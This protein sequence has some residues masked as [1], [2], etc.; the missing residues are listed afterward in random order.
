MAL[1]T[2]TGCEYP[3]PPPGSRTG[4]MGPT[5]YAQDAGWTV[6]ETKNKNFG[7][8]FV[9]NG[10]GVFAARFDISELV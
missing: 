3:A 9:Q 6:I 7:R 5:D 1:Y 2:R 4:T 10:G 8:G